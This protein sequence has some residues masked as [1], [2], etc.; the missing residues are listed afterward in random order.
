MVQKHSQAFQK[1]L[2]TIKALSCPI[3]GADSTKLQHGCIIVPSELDLTGMLISHFTH[4]TAMAQLHCT[5]CGH[6]MLF[7]CRAAKIPL[8]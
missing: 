8:N 6:V 7:D 2:N 1:H 3:C 5:G 4:R